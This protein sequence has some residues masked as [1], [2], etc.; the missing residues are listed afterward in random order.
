MATNFERFQ[1][2]LINKFSVP[3]EKISP[4][5]RM[6]SIGLDSLDT[7]EMLF[8]VEDEFHITVPQ[9]AGEAF[10]VATLQDVVDSISRIAA[11][12]PQPEAAGQK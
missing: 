5:A 9:E 12:T 1:N 3:A 8:E 7:I 4:D 2:I 10:R 6:D 11:E